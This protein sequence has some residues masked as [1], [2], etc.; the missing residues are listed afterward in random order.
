M[1]YLYLILFKEFILFHNVI[2]HNLFNQT[3]IIKHSGCFKTLAIIKNTETKI[4]IKTHIS[5]CS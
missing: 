3:H 5:V 4:L 2:M 1:L